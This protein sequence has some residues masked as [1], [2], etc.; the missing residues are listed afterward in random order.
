LKRRSIDWDEIDAKLV[1]RARR[2]ATAATK[3]K[4]NAGENIRPLAPA[5]LEETA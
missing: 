5:F 4:V 1:E 3:E 2:Q